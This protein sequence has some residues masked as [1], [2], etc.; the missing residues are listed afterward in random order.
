MTLP[1]CP[2]FSDAQK[3][4]RSSPL[5]PWSI[6]RPTQARCIIS[7]TYASWIKTP[8]CLYQ[9]SYAA[10][11][12]CCLQPLARG[13]T[14]GS[15]DIQTSQ[16]QLFLQ[17]LWAPSWGFPPFGNFFWDVPLFGCNI[18]LR[19]LLV[20]ISHLMRPFVTLPQGAAGGGRSTSDGRA[21][22]PQLPPPAHARVL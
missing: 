17:L 2:C 22:G 18:F 13:D 1:V 14:A 6:S 10:C 15:H 4:H 21:T 12:V 16:Q 19:A 8:C 5:C 7:T 3:Q 11:V 20:S 9:N